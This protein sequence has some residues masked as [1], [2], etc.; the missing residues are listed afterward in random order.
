MARVLGLI[1]AR[2]G[3]R[4]LPGKNLLPV[5]G[6]PMIAWTIDAALQSGVLDRVV[7]STD[8]PEIAAAGR[9]AGAEVPF[10]RPAALATDAAPLV[11]V[12]LH[13]LEACGGVEFLVLLQPTS[14]LRTP[15]DIV[16]C[17]E[18]VLAG[19]IAAV[20]VRR[21]SKQWQVFRRLGPDGRLSDCPPPPALPDAMLT[22]AVYAIGVDTLKRTRDF[23]PDGA[24]GVET[25]DDRAIDVDYAAE[26]A[27]CDALLRIRDGR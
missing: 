27:I 24:I 14:P 13:A 11:D 2:G 12:A 10:M 5:A 21:I 4:R 20:T 26:L 9:A 6:R 18:P 25:P 17:L 16:A 22:G 1:P 8:D 19:E 15:G 7:I 23:A 3:S